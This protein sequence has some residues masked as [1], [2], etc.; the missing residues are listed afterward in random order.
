MKHNE[1]KSFIKQEIKTCVE[2][3][4]YILKSVDE[5]NST[6]RF[7]VINPRT[8]KVKAII[9]LFCNVEEYSIALVSKFKPG[10]KINFFTDAYF[11]CSG[12]YLY[13]HN[14]KDF[15]NALKELLK[16][17]NKACKN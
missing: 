5:T 4:N 9:R 17:K 15:L 7:Y 13:L 6:K 11:T 3:Q 16:S 12:S 1:L 14:L 2:D 10:T 8:Y